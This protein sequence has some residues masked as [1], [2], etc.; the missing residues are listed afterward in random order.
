MSN[1]KTVPL[2]LLHCCTYSSAAL[3]NHKN[4]PWISTKRLLFMSARIK[5]GGIVSDIFDFESS[6]VTHSDRYCFPCLGL[7]CEHWKKEEA[8]R[9]S[10]RDPPERLRYDPISFRFETANMWT[11]PF[12]FLRNE[13]ITYVPV[14]YCLLLL[15]DGH[16]PTSNICFHIIRRGHIAQPLMLFLGHSVRSCICSPLAL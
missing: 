10:A 11:K 1:S 3:T 4:H 16:P 9:F 2:D 14:P 13:V 15:P 5:K 6:P 8:G 7:W 12:H